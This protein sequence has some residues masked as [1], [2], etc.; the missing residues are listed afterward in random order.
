MC[1]FCFKC[2]ANNADKNSG[3]LA[4]QWQTLEQQIRYVFIP[5]IDWGLPVFYPPHI[6]TR[7][8]YRK[9]STESRVSSSYNTR[10]GLLL[11]LASFEIHFHLLMILS[12]EFHAYRTLNIWYNGNFMELIMEIIF[13]LQLFSFTLSK[14]TNRYPWCFFPTSLKS[15]QNYILNVSIYL[16]ILIYILLPTLKCVWSCFINQVI[17][18]N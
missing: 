15:V 3:L 5:T 7:T 10:R 14:Y 4:E 12:A 17:Y 16:Y 6:P 2:H 8:E 9:L 13:C 18:R 1:N 11:R